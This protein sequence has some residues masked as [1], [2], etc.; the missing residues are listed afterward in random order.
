[1]PGGYECTVH[2]SFAQRNSNR[3]SP[4]GREAH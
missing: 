2:W 1:M 4:G 3:L